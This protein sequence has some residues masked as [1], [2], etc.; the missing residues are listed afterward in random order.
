MKTCPVCQR[1]YAD[2]TMMF[3]LADG[4][5]LVNV[6]RRLDLDATWRFTPP[7]TQPS[8]TVAA[9]QT[10]EPRPQSTIQ[11][12]PELHAAQ[13]N[14][15]TSVPNN[16]RSVLPWIFGMVVVL[17]GS[18]ILIVVLITRSRNSQSAQLPTATQQQSSPSPAIE[19]KTAD[20]SVATS[21]I[22]ANKGKSASTQTTVPAIKSLIITDRNRNSSERP[23]REGS[24]VASDKKKVE[25]PKPTGESFIPVSRP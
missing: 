15:V 11:Y 24:K 7:K 3:C 6:S 8:P 14:T 17:A 10:D 2:E 13:P 18:A 25:Q 20:K 21:P 4:A 1:P 5:E 9:P 12:R 16:T 19:T 22:N 23:K